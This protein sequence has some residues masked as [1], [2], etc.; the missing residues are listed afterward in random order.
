MRGFAEVYSALILSLIT[1]LALAA[2][3]LAAS[4]AVRTAGVVSLSSLQYTPPRMELNATGSCENGYLQAELTV[5]ASSPAAR[6]LELEVWS[7]DGRLVSTWRFNGS[8]VSFRIPCV[9]SYVLAVRFRYGVWLYSFDLDP[10]KPCLHGRLVSAETLLSSRCA[11]WGGLALVNSGGFSALLAASRLVPAWIHAPLKAGVEPYE[12]AAAGVVPGYDTPSDIVH[13]DFLST[14]ISRANDFE[15]VHV[16]DYVTRSNPV[17]VANLHIASATVYMDSHILH[18]VDRWF[19]AEFN[20]TEAYREARIYEFRVELNLTSSG[21]VYQS[22]Y[23]ASYGWGTATVT[24]TAGERVVAA[25]SVGSIYIPFLVTDG[26]PSTRLHVE[27]IPIPYLYTVNE[28]VYPLWSPYAS[29]C[30][31]LTYPN[32]VH[33]YGGEFRVPLY[34][35][36]RIHVVPVNEYDPKQLILPPEYSTLATA[37]WQSRI[38]VPYKT[39]TVLEPVRADAPVEI[40]VT[41]SPELLG[42]LQEAVVVLEISYAAGW[43]GWAPFKFDKAGYVGISLDEG[44]V[45]FVGAEFYLHITLVGSKWGAAGLIAFPPGLRPVPGEAMESI[46][47][48]VPQEERVLRGCTGYYRVA[49]GGEA[50]GVA[51]L[52]R[53]RGVYTITE[54]YPGSLTDGLAETLLASS[55][56]TSITFPP[57]LLTLY[58]EKGAEV[59]VLEPTITRSS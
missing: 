33:I 27:V 7:I 4:N 13:I 55:Q 39:F 59:L 10:S 32:W 42:G 18:I 40:S 22:P 19:V 25:G 26:S 48:Y 23:I 30:P 34:V 14:N 53:V 56:L 45:G 5:Y 36:A 3:Y 46:G 37:G 2:V 28:Y 57:D 35:S 49:V 54:S 9:G 43:S 1:I 20:A 51:V 11:W 8:T 31:P 52:Y 47:I 21:V 44:L 12:A 38:T 41:I 16:Y 6:P 58:L 15:E 29:S 17:Q 50:G 24:S